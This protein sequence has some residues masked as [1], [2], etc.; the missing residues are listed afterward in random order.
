MA[1]WERSIEVEATPAR[2]W[3]VMADVA[4]WPEWTE[5]ILSVEEVSPDFGKGGTAL[6]H[7]KGQSRSKFTV[8][9]WEP[10]R[11]FDWET[12]SRGATAVGGHWIE[13]A[14]EGRSRV[15]LSVEVGGMV[16]TLLKPLLSKGVNGNLEMEAAGLKR[17]SE[18][19]ATDA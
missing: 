4:R 19:P 11:G 17:R 14:G 9:T 16:A 2:V 5:S 3:N 10:G 18:S 7:A 15:T 8:T 13:P 12:K 1:R 6:V